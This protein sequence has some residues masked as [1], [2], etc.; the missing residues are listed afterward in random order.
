M[1]QSVLH[2]RDKAR[3]STLIAQFASS[4]ANMYFQIIKRAYKLSAMVFLYTSGILLNLVPKPSDS[5]PLYTPRNVI[6]Q[7]PPPQVRDVP[8]IQRSPLDNLLVYHP[9]KRSHSLNSHACGR[10]C[11]L[12]ICMHSQ[13]RRVYHS[14]PCL[15]GCL[16][17]L[18]RSILLISVWYR[19][20]WD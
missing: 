2:Y 19:C 3:R 10:P 7:H 17:D 16:H 6:P 14:F 18:W 13:R 1:Y 11:S 8:C 15:Y 5:Q 20:F 12:R 4:L 9:R